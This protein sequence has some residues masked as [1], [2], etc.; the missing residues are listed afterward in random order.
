MNKRA[1]RN[2]GSQGTFNQSNDN[3][4]EPS[5]ITYKNMAKGLN[6]FNIKS[7]ATPKN[8]VS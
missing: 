2:K 4:L 7:G 5:L 6:S 3:I 1:F 8:L